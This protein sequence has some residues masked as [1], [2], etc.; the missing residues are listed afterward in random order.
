MGGL[1]SGRCQSSIALHSFKS[2][3]VLMEVHTEHINISSGHADHFPLNFTFAESSNTLV[4]MSWDHFCLGLPYLKFKY[5][6]VEK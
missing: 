1:P 4:S 5:K 3:V 6:A 2:Y